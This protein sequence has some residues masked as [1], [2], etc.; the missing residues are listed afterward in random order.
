MSKKSGIFAL[1]ILTAF[2]AAGCGSQGDNEKYAAE[3]LKSDIFAAD[4]AVIRDCLG[5]NGKTTLRW[6]APNARKVEIHVGSAEGNLF[7]ISGA[8]GSKETGYWVRDGMKF[9]L[10]DGD[11]G[12]ELAAISVKVLGSQ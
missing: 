3:L 7:T 5:E 12:E 4:P 6:N 8:E 9:V 11:T 1:F 10:L 2:L